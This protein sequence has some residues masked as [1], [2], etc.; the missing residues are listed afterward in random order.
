MQR[1]KSRSGMGM[2]MLRASGVFLLGLLV[3]NQMWELA[4]R[5]LPGTLASRLLYWTCILLRGADVVPADRGPWSPTRGFA[6]LGYLIAVAMFAGAGWTAVRVRQGLVPSVSGRRPRVRGIAL[7]IVL[8]CGGLILASVVEA[9]NGCD[10]FQGDTRLGYVFYVAG[11]A[12]AFCGGPS[13]VAGCLVALLGCAARTEWMAGLL[14]VVA[15]LCVQS[16]WTAIV[17]LEI[18][19]YPVLTG[20]VC[21]LA[22]IALGFALRPRERQ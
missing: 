14:C 5:A 16:T 11:Q 17:L 22:G 2:S 13:F 19:W 6:T 7:A 21:L 4:Y 15:W 9:V 20:V 3:L 8:G 10:C 1:R 12:A 18:Y